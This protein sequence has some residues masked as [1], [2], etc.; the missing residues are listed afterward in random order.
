MFVENMT[1]TNAMTM[2]W[3]ITN[4]KTKTTGKTLTMTMTIATSSHFQDCFTC[5]KCFQ[6]I[7][8]DKVDERFLNG[9]DMHFQMTWHTG[10]PK[11]NVRKFIPSN[12]T[13]TFI[14][15][16]ELLVQNWGEIENK[17]GKLFLMTI[18]RLTFW[19]VPDDKTS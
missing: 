4:T 3:T 13:L 10:P 11:V 12:V 6:M 19:P 16:F 7:F 8:Y 14:L 2:T 17:G 15:N 9:E 18:P 1:E 5:S